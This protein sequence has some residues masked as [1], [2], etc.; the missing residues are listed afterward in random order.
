M[1]EEGYIGRRGKEGEIHEGRRG[2]G[3]GRRERNS[4]RN[5][6]QIHLS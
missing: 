5:A 4:I 6:N 3:G 2:G 1:E